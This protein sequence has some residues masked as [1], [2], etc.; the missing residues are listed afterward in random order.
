MIVFE[1]IVKKEQ[2][3]QLIWGDG[4]VFLLHSCV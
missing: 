4:L 3:K 1:T 2:K